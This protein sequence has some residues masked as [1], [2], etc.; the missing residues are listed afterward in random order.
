MEGGGGEEE[1]VS[2]GWT[3]VRENLVA[4]WVK[5]P[6]VRMCWARLAVRGGIVCGAMCRDR[7]ATGKRTG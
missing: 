2:L 6:V 1:E 7:G 4:G 3:G 5:S